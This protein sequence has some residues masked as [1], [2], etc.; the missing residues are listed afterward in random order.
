[1]TVKLKKLK[2]QVIV[3]TGASSGNGLATVHLAAKQGARLVLAARSEDTL[4]QITDEITRG[5]G[6]AVYVVA[7]VGKQEDVR[8][9]ARVAKEA[10]GGFDTWVNDAGVSIYGKLEDTPIEDMRH[11]FETNVWGMVYGSLEAARH[12]KQ[13]GGAIINIGST[14]SDR[15]IPLQGIYSASKHAVKGFTDALR[16]ELEGEGAPVSVTLIKPGAIATP[17]N[18]HAKN[19]MPM[20]PT[21][22][23]PT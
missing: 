14:V 3:I 16:M 21:L 23:P 8:E 13:S 15:A 19:Y 9:I 22:P 1:M 4:R 10:F 5:G 17:Y 11:L 18:D 12:L 20:E 6:E 7:D 2:N